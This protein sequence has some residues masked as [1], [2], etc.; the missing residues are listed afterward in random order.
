[1]N[2]HEFI[3]N[4]QKCKIAALDAAFYGTNLKNDYYDTRVALEHVLFS[5]DKDKHYY[6]SSK[7]GGREMIKLVDDID[8]LHILSKFSMQAFSLLK[9][10][11]NVQKKV[12][13]ND[14]ELIEYIAYLA[15]NNH[16]E[17]YCFLRNNKNIRLRLFK[18][19]C[20]YRYKKGLKELLDDY[21]GD[22]DI[23]VSD[24]VRNQ[25]KKQY[26]NIDKEYEN[27]RKN[28]II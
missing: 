7:Y 19:L 21:K 2:E 18:L 16:L 10:D 14:E 13:L 27:I 28:A 5:L 17:A 3:K 25:Y 15:H 23:K 20:F 1:M 11:F 26:R 8:V 6:V 4:F 9:K 24:K 12:N 22:L